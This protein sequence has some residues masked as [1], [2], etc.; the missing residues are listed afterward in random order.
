MEPGLFFTLSVMSEKLRSAGVLTGHLGET[1]TPILA[2]N[3][4]SFWRGSQ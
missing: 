3:W 1:V 2:R 4:N